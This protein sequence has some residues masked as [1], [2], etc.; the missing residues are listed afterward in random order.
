M[1]EYTPSTV[2]DP[3][4]PS[5]GSSRLFLTGFMGAGKSTVGPLVADRLGYAFIDLDEAITDRA[6]QPISALFET[7]EDAFR[8]LESTLLR[9]VS[10]QEG[11]VVATGGGALA[12]ETNLSVAQR[13][14]VV[15]YLRVAVDVLAHRLADTA[16]ERP[17]LQNGEGHPLQG[18]ALHERIQALL[19]QRKLRYQQADVIVDAEQSPEAVASAIVKSLTAES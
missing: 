4:R 7:G 5:A 13:A 17:L 16:M 1:T 9:E 11:V 14:G 3:A 18:N 6:E 15:V 2:P 19:D 12:S 10:Q 8:A